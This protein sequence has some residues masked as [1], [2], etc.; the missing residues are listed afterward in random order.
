MQ[1]AYTPLTDREGNQTM[2]N[3]IILLTARKWLFRLQLDPRVS[4]SSMTDMSAVVESNKVHLQIQD[5][6][7][8][9][10]YFH[11]MQFYTSSNYNFI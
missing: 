6:C 7:N 9:L 5:T 2:L 8:L 3:K 1:A 10:E 11:V 4:H